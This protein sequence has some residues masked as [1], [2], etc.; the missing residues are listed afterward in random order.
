MDATTVR[1][2]T[3]LRRQVQEAWEAIGRETLQALV[4]TMSDRC[5]NVIMANGGHTK[6]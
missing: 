6:W 3:E 1:Q 5:F 2:K 4:R